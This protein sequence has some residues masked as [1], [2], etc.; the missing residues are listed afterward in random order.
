MLMRDLIFKD[1]ENYF[2]FQVKI[3]SCWSKK[4]YAGSKAMHRNNDAG[5]INSSEKQRIIP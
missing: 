3:S 1:V 2:A 5:T 4:T